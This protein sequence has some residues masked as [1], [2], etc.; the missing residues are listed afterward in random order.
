LT[1]PYPFELRL[2]VTFR[3][4]DVLGHINNAVYVTWFE[5]ARTAYIMELCALKRLE[6]LPVILAETTIRYIAQGEF[7]ETVVIGTG[8]SRW[9]T[10]SFDLAYGIS[11]TTGRVLATGRSVQVYYDYESRKTVPIPQQFR[12]VVADRQGGWTPP[13]DL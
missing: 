6:D 8:V 4:I 11:T 7:G 12:G 5:A 13:A 1:T 2:P 9:G 3:D 10:K